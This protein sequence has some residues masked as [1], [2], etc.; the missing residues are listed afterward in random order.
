MKS[1]NPLASILDMNRLTGPNF[2]DWFRNLKIVLNS[3]RI[4]YVL[5]TPQPAPLVEEATEQE[6]DAYN[7]WHADDMQARCYMLASMTNELQ[8]QHENMKT[9]SEVLLHLKELYGEQSRSA[10]YE[11]SKQLFQA[12]MPEGSDVGTHVQRMIRL[13][14]QLENLEFYMDFNLHLDLILQSLPESFSQFIVNFHMN[15]IECTLAN[16]HNMLVTAQKAMTSK[17]KEKLLVASTSGKTKK[18][19][20]NKKN[21][22][23]K[24]SVGVSKKKGKKKQ[25]A[26]KGKCFH[27]GKDGHWKRNCPQ[28]L[29][30]LKA[31]KGKGVPSEGMSISCCFNSN[32]P[33]SSYTAWV[34][35]TGASSHI[36]TSMQELASSRVLRSNEVT[37]KIGN[38][39]SVAAKAV[40]STS[41]LLMNNHVMFLD[42]VLVLPNA[43][44]NIIS[45]SSL[46]K[47][48]YYFDF[49]D[50]VCNIY[51]GNNVVGVGYLHDGLYYLS[52]KNKASPRIAEMNAITNSTPSLKQLWHL[53]LG[54][55]AEDRIN[56]LEKMGLLVPLG[57][58]PTLTCESCLQGKMTRSP[59][60]GQ[61]ERAKE[62]LEL[63]HSD[64]CGPFSAMARGGY[65][66][67]I[68]FTD[69]LSRYG[70]VYLMKNKHESFEKFKEFKSEVEKQIGKNI[71]VL[72]SD[73]GGEYLST[74]FD[75][76][77]KLHGIISQ[78]TPPGTPQLNGVS[79][80]RNRTLLNMVRSMMSYT[81][82][83]ISFWGY[84]LYTACYILNRIPS[85]SVPTTP[86]EI[87]K[88][89]KPSL[90]H[91][92]IWGC[93][94]FIKKL[95]TD[96]LET[97][98]L[99]GRFVGYP[100]DSFGY[101]FYLP[102]E[103]RVVI[104]R[105]AIFL[106]KEFVQEGGIGR[107]IK[108][109]EESSAQQIDQ[110]SEPMDIDQPVKELIQNENV[111]EPRRSSRVIR[112]PARY[113]NLHENVQELFIHGDND[114]KDD[115]TTY[116]E[117]ISD[118]DSSKWL[119]AMKSE[120]DS[121]YSN[122]VWDLVDPP[123]G[124]VPI[125]NKWIYKRK[126]GPDGKVETFKARLVA[127]GYRQREGVDYEE[128]FS[129][130]AMLKSIRI[131]L[132]IAAHYD[133]EVWQMDVK[134]AF[135]NGYIEEHI[136][137][138][139]PK[140]FES[141]DKSKVCKLKRSIY[142]LKQASRS[143]NL[144]FD[145]AIKSF[146]FIKNEDEPCVYKK[147]SGSKIAFLVLYV[148]DILLIGNDVGM[149]TTVK[150]WLSKTFSMKDLGE[151]T[152]I[153][154]I[155]IYRDRSKRLIGLSQ[156]LYLDKV[157]KRFNMLDSKRGLL[158]VRHGIHLSKAMSPK[159]PEER[160]KMAKVPYASAI[161]SL[162]YAMLCTRPD[163]AYAVSITSRFQSDPGLEHWVA[164][165]NILKYL[166]RTKDLVLVYGGNGLK[167]DGFTDSDFQS[168]VDDRKSI[169]GYIFTCNGGAVS[170]KS[171]KQSTTADSTTEAEYIAASDAA[172]EAVWIRKFVTELG[173]VPSISSPLALHCDNNGAIAQA[174]EPRAHQKS[175]HIERRFHIIREIVGRGDIAMQKVASADNVADP[176]TK[177]M[178]Q[179][180]LDKHLEKMGLRYCTEWL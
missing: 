96:K 3:E 33:Y 75:E 125:G 175:K 138:D 151:A 93:P 26:D 116:D 108:L 12:K 48:G 83:P 43:Y 45:I 51:F 4:G 7:K 73:R 128:T 76:F 177:A 171:S 146:D 53:R 50:N 119:E 63:V 100:N 16:L 180:Q 82:L 55:V 150:V 8:K 23:P 41:L 66:Y 68:T 47:V 126:I 35:D 57:S 1:M 129:P 110:V 79:E 2:V 85:K 149:L 24:S 67:F 112:P 77:L 22:V 49:K 97:R 60:V 13:I 37:L 127:K 172:K 165:K 80:R 170:W 11:I 19:K 38:G 147:V 105:D 99:K 166:R 107:E 42:H 169:S 62:V 118:I 90:K 140:G 161:G 28:Y 64:V 72:R 103:Q 58:E 86:F 9:A 18:N 176:L 148:D 17:G 61:M 15:K 27:C 130:V 152:Y 117:A 56:K 163:I 142:G 36:C 159:T 160:E 136:F 134:T 156:S 14:E 115:P 155:R 106:E 29:E 122:Q 39:A 114:H 154:G 70:Y 91:V 173:V 168:D 87:W 32:S 81:D 121:M 164:I 31:S 5:D 158:P 52:T 30:E 74:E 102:T 131:L 89:R 141:K 123:E 111:T 109:D 132:A 120:M 143:W 92:K 174:K 98:S 157:L 69:D 178:T 133:Y 95:N 71:K 54:H 113:L 124:I 153:L 135:L 162:M 65:H 137:M 101:Y 10:R 59:F 44:R 25:V 88:G 139:Q 179:Q 167:L 21:S 94:A 84:A 40:G 20:K 145:E 6:I 104:S 34:L 144:R 78:R 46:T